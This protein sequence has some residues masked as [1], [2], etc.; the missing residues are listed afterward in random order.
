MRPRFALIL[1]A[2]LTLAASPAVHAAT[3]YTVTTLHFDTIV[4]PLDDTHCD[5]VG[6]L[7]VPTSAT[8]SHPAPAILTTNGFGGAKDDASQKTIADT[9]AGAG[10]VVLS[11]SGLGFGGSGCKITLDDPDWD[12]KAARQLVDF[13]ATLP[14][15]LRDRPGDPRIG[16]IGG[17]YGGQIQ[18]AVA[19]IDPR[20]DALIPII[21]WNDLTYSLAPQRV[22]KKEWTSLFFGLGI[23]DGVT[24]AQNDPTRLVG[25]P[26]FT[27][28]A[29]T[30][31]A[32]LEALGYPT[33]AT[34]A[35]ARRV[36]VVSYVDRIHAPTLLVQ[37]QADTL[38]NLN[39]AARTYAALR[40]QG[41]PVSMVWQ[42]WGHSN[43]TPAPG[44]SDYLAGRYLQWFAHY[45]RH[46]PASP[47]PTFSYYRA[48]TGSY[49]SAS[50]YPVG[51]ATA[52]SLVT[53]T[54]SYANAPGGV[55]TSYSE[56]S[57]LQGSTVPDQS[58][59]PADA[60]GTFASW[61]SPPLTGDLVTVGASTLDITLDCPAA[62][63]SQATGPAGQLVVFAKLYDVA[64]DGTITL[65][66][67]LISPTRV[68]DVTKPVHIELPG[69]VQL[70][71]AGHRIRLVLA[72]SDAAYAGNVPVFPVTVHSGQ[73]QLLSLPV[74]GPGPRFQA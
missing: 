12:G 56:T 19:S 22:H 15:V 1:A 58:T 61:T 73:S 60:P 39:E 25:C 17:S 74:V 16:M 47:G 32:E 4:G 53:D 34:E 38:F 3:G 59:P 42:S 67:R 36:S 63:L 5:V 41:T 31:K 51:R 52:L 8:A 68:L 37:G 28:E 69:T 40:A 35:L 2:A 30:A 49:V 33:P 45:L 71:R 72:A 10:Y 64:P 54:Q 18:F 70:W 66:N 57:A 11:Y 65:W 44:E 26:N 43:S 24:G 50:G 55:P 9:L 6:D 46:D 27:D 21:T 13:L 48:W 29:C 14:E 62:A 20:V 7:Y 23:V